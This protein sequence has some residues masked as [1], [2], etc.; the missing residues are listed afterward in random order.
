MGKFDDID[1]R[2]RKPTLRCPHCGERLVRLSV[3]PN[4][5]ESYE[6][7][8]WVCDSTDHTLRLEVSPDEDNS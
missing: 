1:L 8:I 6:L 5:G 4:I 2:M 3:K 7:N